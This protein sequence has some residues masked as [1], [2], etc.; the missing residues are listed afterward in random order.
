MP[1]IL[2]M[3]KPFLYV[4]AQ[5]L[6]VP[7]SQCATSLPS[8]MDQVQE[9]GIDTVDPGKMA[10][11]VGYNQAGDVPEHLDHPQRLVIPYVARLLQ[12][13][14]AHAVLT[15]VRVSGHDAPYHQQ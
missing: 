12:S 5:C 2:Q 7:P 1:L 13:R 14:D 15:H 10:Q 3:S 4:H 6:D 11:A 9:D 8:P